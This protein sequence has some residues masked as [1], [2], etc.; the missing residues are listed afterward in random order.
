M[1]ISAQLEPRLHLENRRYAPRRS[2]RIGSA[3]DGFDEEVVI[4]DLSTTGLLLET[5]GDLTDGE[6]LLVDLPERGPT[7]ATVMWSKGRF[8]GCRFDDGIS[9]Y[10]VSAALLKS[11]PASAV[12]DGPA[13][14]RPR[15]VPR[16]A[17]LFALFAVL[18][19]AAMLL[20]PVT[21]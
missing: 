18:L 5:S 9:A 15:R 21:R 8:F 3:L 7:P 12:G 11:S 2:L 13:V 4:H 6:R 19:L 14:E 10:A 1:T 16:A 20:L 17:L